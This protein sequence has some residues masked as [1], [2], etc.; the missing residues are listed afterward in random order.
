MV[1]ENLSFN[2]SMRA[3]RPVSSNM[4]S[5]ASEVTG[6]LLSCLSCFDSTILFAHFFTP[7]SI[8]SF[9]QQNYDQAC[10]LRERCAAIGAKITFPGRW[11]YP[12]EFQWLE[13]PPRFLSYIGQPIWLERPSL[14]V[15]GSREPHARTLEWLDQHLT[16]VL[17]KRNVLVVSGAARGVD[18]R[19]HLLS[20]RC[21]QPT[22]AFLP[23][24]LATPYPSSFSEMSS[25]I[26][27]A[28]GAVMS[29]YPPNQSMRKY[30]FLQRN[31]LIASLAKVVFIAEASRR[32]GSMMTARLA[33]AGRSRICVLPSF[34]GDGAG[35]GTL[36]LLVEGA[37]PLRDAD[38]LMSVCDLEMACTLK[39]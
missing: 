6:E 14:A 17:R 22:L 31:R 25:A 11:D 37:T 15:V 19:A 9:T 20:V 28:G 2:Q 5:P 32:S 21:G 38:D 8:Q 7:S 29:E 27:E 1:F 10:D 3:L 12:S 24:G 35:S 16:P 18:Q 30:H 4:S 26:L 13:K 33:Q 39:S 23:S 36:E 34:P